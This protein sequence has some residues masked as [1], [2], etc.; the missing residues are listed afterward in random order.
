M[1]LVSILSDHVPL[2]I[3]SKQLNIHVGNISL[4]D[5]FE[6]DLSEPLN[7]PEEFALSLCSDL[8]LGGEFATAI[9]YSI[10]GQLNWHSKTYAFSEAPLPSVETAIRSGTDVD[11]WGPYLETLTDAEMEKKLRDQD[12]NTRFVLYC[13]CFFLTV[14][15]PIMYQWIE[16]TST[17]IFLQFW[18]LLS[19]C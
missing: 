6:W 16:L 18:Q 15:S 14:T 11:N 17:L 10:R 8:G 12:R 9:A 13:I 1:P 5:Q 4:M 7:S 19:R 3:S 2:L